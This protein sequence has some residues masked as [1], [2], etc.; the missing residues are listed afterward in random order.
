MTWRNYEPAYPPCSSGPQP[1]TAALAAAL[2]AYYGDTGQAYS[3]GIYNCRT[4][5]GSSAWSLHS[6]GRAFD[7]GLR[8]VNGQPNALGD[9]IIERL[10]P[11][12]GA[13]GLC[14]AIWNRRRYS[15][16]YPGGTYYSGASPHYDHIH[17]GQT[18]A[19]A[20][21]LTYDTAIQLITTSPVDDSDPITGDEF[22]MA[23]LDDLRTIVRDE[24]NTGTGN[25]QT[26]WADTSRATL[27]TVQSL[28]L[29][30]AAILRGQGRPV[31]VGADD[32]SP[33]RYTLNEDGTLTHITDDADRAAL[34]SGGSPVLLWPRA[35]VD[36]L[37]DTA[38]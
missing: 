20:L 12:A 17:I 21:F 23:T 34:Q 10:R 8:M 36:S 18:W 9:K 2:L 28:V 6:D 25:G 27:A 11:I 29:P 15:D 22:D 14:E 37:L 33:E 13:L 32:G 7:L 1:G 16:D 5:G 26:S 24:L 31:I 30:V 3:L 4:A 38:A 35:S 19:G